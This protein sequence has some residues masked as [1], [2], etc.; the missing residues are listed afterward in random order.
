M[1]YSGT[2][3]CYICRRKAFFPKRRKRLCRIEIEEKRV[4]TGSEQKTALANG[5]IKRGQVTRTNHKGYTVFTIGPTS[6]IIDGHA[7]KYYNRTHKTH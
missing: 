7:T 2:K 3:K 6:N 4:I 5:E 1:Q